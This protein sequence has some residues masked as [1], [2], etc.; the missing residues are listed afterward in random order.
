M[1]RESI[2]KM[3]D[4]TLGNLTETAQATVAKEGTWVVAVPRLLETRG[5]RVWCKGTE[6]QTET[7][8]A[9]PAP[10]MLELSERR[11][12]EPPQ[13]LT[14]S[15]GGA[16][17]RRT[18][19]HGAAHNKPWWQ[20]WR[21]RP[22]ASSPEFTRRGRWPRGWPGAGPGRPGAGL[23]RRHYP[24]TK[25]GEMMP[26][27]SNPLAVRHD[28]NPRWDLKPLSGDVAAA[29]GGGARRRGSSW[30]PHGQAI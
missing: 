11:P 12:T 3:V 18:S 20:R 22:R 23:G 27:R 30:T 28:A 21:Y 19:G 15:H 16:A 9:S 14:K 8:I 10:R 29:D 13:S 6:V 4:L 2:D 1:A 7:R 24:H 17:A 26:G 5:F 25:M